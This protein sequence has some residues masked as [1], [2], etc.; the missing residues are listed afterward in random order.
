MLEKYGIGK[1]AVA[2]V[3]ASAEAEAPAEGHTEKRQRVKA[4]K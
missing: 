2:A 1:P 4:V 3:A